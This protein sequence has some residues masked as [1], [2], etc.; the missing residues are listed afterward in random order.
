MLN[1][2]SFFQIDDFQITLSIQ[3]IPISHNGFDKDFVL[4]VLLFELNYYK[5]AIGL[6]IIPLYSNTQAIPVNPSTLKAGHQNKIYS[7]GYK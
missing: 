6:R 5:N 2:C 1:N 4:L 7:S 3:A